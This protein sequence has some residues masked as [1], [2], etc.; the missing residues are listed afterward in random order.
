V[1]VCRDGINTLITSRKPDDL[2][3]FCRE[4]TKAFAETRVLV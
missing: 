2:N 1:A 3:A 4:F